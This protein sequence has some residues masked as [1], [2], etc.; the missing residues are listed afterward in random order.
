MVIVDETSLECFFPIW[1]EFSE[2]KP[3]HRLEEDS[4]KKWEGKVEET[5]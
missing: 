5:C 3:K 2:N 1:T 4:S